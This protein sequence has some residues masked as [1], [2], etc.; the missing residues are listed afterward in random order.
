VI[1]KERMTAGFMTVG[2]RHA[3]HGVWRRISFLP[4]ALEFGNWQC[5]IRGIYPFSRLL[6]IVMAHVKHCPFGST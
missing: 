4:Y 2:V 5:M 3:L 6:C 1:E